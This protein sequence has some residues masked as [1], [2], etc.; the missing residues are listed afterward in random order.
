MIDKEE[1]RII[2]GVRDVGVG[3][4]GELPGTS[5]VLDLSKLP[6][7]PVSA[8]LNFHCT[9]SSRTQETN[10]HHNVLTYGFPILLCSHHTFPLLL[11]SLRHSPAEDHKLRMRLYSKDDFS[12]NLKDR[13]TCGF[14]ELN[15]A[16]LRF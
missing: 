4:G 10:I 3:K 5:S 15:L 16:S 13:S 11:C 6:T 12:M 8:C 14:M 9:H 7:Y 2:C 1:E